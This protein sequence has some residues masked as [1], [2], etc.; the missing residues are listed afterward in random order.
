MKKARAKEVCR[1]ATL[2]WQRANLSLSLS[3]G[4]GVRASAGCR[5][6]DPFLP[7]PSALFYGASGQHGRSGRRR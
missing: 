5:Y 2:P 7:V 4:V 6:G 1:W 3:G